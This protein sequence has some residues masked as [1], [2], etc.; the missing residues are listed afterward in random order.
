MVLRMEWEHH[1]DGTIAQ[2]SVNA[3]INEFRH[4]YEV[5]LLGIAV[6]VLSFNGLAESAL[7]DDV[8]PQI[9]L[10]EHHHSSHHTITLEAYNIS[11]VNVATLKH[12]FRGPQQLCAKKVNNARVS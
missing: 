12:R 7:Q 10:L 9:L 8:G 1:P 5:C 2:I 6:P 3:C 4:R 11:N